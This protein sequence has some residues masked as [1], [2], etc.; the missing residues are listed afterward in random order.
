MFVLASLLVGPRFPK[1]FILK[2][3]SSLKLFHFS[4]SYVSLLIN[5]SS[6]SLYILVLYAY[7]LHLVD[8]CLA[9]ADAC[10]TEITQRPL[11]VF[12]ARFGVLKIH[13]CLLE[14]G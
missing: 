3:W 5:A 6:S 9:G 7:T 2:F 10:H 14:I 1:C 11:T 13:A 4:R 12:G 8:L